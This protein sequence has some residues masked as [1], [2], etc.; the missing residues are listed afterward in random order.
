[1]TATKFEVA[2]G[3]GVITVKTGNTLAA[4]Y[5]ETMTLKAVDGGSTVMTGSATI[6]V[7]VKDGCCTISGAGIAQGALA[8]IV[9]GLLSL[10]M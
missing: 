9:L 10:F 6:M 8:V 5:E 1:M 4:N 2:A 7:C 3:T